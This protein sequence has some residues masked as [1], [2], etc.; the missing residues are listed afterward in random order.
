MV[1]VTAEFIHSGKVGPGGWC[2]AQLK[3]LGV[4]WPPKAGWI[5]GLASRNVE[6]SE[7]AAELFLG[8]GAGSVSKTKIR[9][10]N[11]QARKAKNHRLIGQQT[12]RDVVLDA[13]ESTQGEPSMS[14]EAIEYAEQSLAAKDLPAHDCALRR[15]ILAARA[16]LAQVEAQ[17][18]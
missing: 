12:G 3:L 15:D 9:K 7:A 17:A 18:A 2:A 6:I 14:T 11:R 10:H 4:A 16:E 8:Y 5:E 1:R 13:R